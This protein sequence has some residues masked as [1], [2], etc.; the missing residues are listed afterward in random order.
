MRFGSLSLPLLRYVVEAD[1]PAAAARGQAMDPTTVLGAGTMAMLLVGMAS[2]AGWLAA[3]RRWGKYRVWIL[4]SSIGM[5]IPLLLF[6]PQTGRPLVTVA[7]IAANGLT[8]SAGAFITSAL[9]CQVIDVDEFNNGSRSEGA[10]MVFSTLLPKFVAIPGKATPEE[11]AM[12]G[13]KFLGVG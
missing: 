9:L 5:C 10:F 7:L 1:G 6:I 4:V 13:G 12:M 2:S 11:V 3:V 8:V